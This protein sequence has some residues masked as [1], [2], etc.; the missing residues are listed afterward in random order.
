MNKVLALFFAIILLLCDMVTAF[1]SELEES[2]ISYD[3]LFASE[4]VCASIIQKRNDEQIDR[5]FDGEVSLDMQH[6]VPIYVP[7]GTSFDNTLQSVLEFTNTYNTTVYSKSGEV[8]GTATLAFYENKWV[9]GA[10]YNGYNILE[11]IG[12]IPTNTNQTFYYI[13]NPYKN[14]KALLIVGQNTEIYRSLTN[15]RDTVNASEI[16][17]DINEIQRLNN[18]L[19]NGTDVNAHSTILIL[20]IISACAIITFVIVALIFIYRQKTRQ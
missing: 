5:F 8:L 13:D 14:E 16:V 7:T 19:D 9:V 3:T 1:A 15:S 17:N 18:M 6:L 11:K 20:H 4:A 10:F 2:D 12:T